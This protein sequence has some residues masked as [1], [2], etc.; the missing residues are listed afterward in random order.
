MKIYLSCFPANGWGV[1]S[2]IG[3]ALSE[4][5]QGLASHL[6]SSIDFSKHD[7]GLTSD[8]KHDHYQ[9][10]YPEGYELIWVDDADTDPRWQAALKLNK[11]SHSDDE[12]KDIK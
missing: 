1:G 3:F 7:M 6:S 4:D 9:K 12:Q 8:W 2:V 10:S 5:G 11:A